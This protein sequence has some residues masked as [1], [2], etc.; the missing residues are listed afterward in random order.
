MISVLLAMC[1][2]AVLVSLFS[3]LPLDAQTPGAAEPA[4]VMVL[5]TYHFANP[6]LDVVQ[7]EVDDVLS[8][9]RQ[10]EIHE[11]VEA[12]E[13]FRP[14]KIAVEQVPAEA[15][16]LD[17]LY[18]AYRAGQHE[19]MRSETEQLGFRLAAR[20]EHPRVYPI[21]YRGALPFDAVLEYAQAHDPAFLGLFHQEIGRITEEANR[22]Q[23]EQ[24]VGEI[25]RFVNDPKTQS[26][27]HG[28]YLRIASVGAGDT[29]VGAE[30]LSK[31]YDRNI[32]IHANLQAIAEPGDRIL[33]II[34][35]GHAPILR[36]LISY[37]PEMDLVEAQEF[38]PF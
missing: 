15:A 26:A 13:R 17:S 1:K 34:G 19:L 6:G 3:F 24:T 9:A 32:R 29:Y 18:L 11:L 4:H 25:L 8:D 12:I 22:Q 31:W 35:H 7:T 16:R 38:L 2:A 27:G 36:E 10:A 33:I 28:L 23:R 20:L 37:D 5:G 21:D 14:T 30:V